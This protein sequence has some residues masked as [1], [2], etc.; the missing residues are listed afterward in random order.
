MIWN[1]KLFL[2]IFPFLLWFNPCAAQQ[3]YEREYSI[4]A[5]AVPK[6]AVE[7]INSVFKNEKIR[8]YGE[9]SLTATTIEAKLK[10]GGKS[11]SIEF[12]KS[13][14]I[15]DVEM[16]IAFKDISTGTRKAI[17]RNLGDKFKSYKIRKVQRQ[18]SGSE[19][20]LKQALKSGNPS[21]SV[22]TRYELVLKGRKK[23]VTNY[24]EVLF[25]SKGAIVSISEIVQRNSDNLI[26]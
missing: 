26:Y 21:K 1:K 19:G 22:V 9:E 17:E 8:W 3:K 15:Q 14:E 7:F 13:G 25:G 6:K 2:L 4:K 18:W 16:L 12:D 10:S 23:S 20:D 24:Y 5:S 11:Y